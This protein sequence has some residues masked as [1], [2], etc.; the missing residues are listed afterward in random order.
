MR[1]NV[2][3]ACCVCMFGI[4]ITVAQPVHAQS[5]NDQENYYGDK[6]RP[7]VNINAT[8]RDEPG[9]DVC[10]PARAHITVIGQDADNLYV[11]LDD[12]EKDC[13][14]GAILSASVAYS[15]ERKVIDT[16]GMTRTGLTYGALVIPFKYQTT[17][18]KDFTGSATVGGYMGYRFETLRKL[19]F[20]ATPVAFMGASNISADKKS[21]SGSENVMGFSFGVGLI[22]TLKGAFQVGI[23]AGW[24]RVGQ[25]TD[26]QY[27]GDMWI[28][29]EIG[30]AFL[31]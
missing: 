19:G 2:F 16:S 7:S 23:V 4:A 1:T 18:D 21:G 24:D 29:A 5:V 27:N 20:T 15:I 6:L 11:K 12:D 9:T 28:A 8:I 17:G 25:N 30:Y 3:T 26:Y 14:N 22:G 13:N 31:Q 10:I